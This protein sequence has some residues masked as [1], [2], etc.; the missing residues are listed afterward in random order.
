MVADQSPQVH[1]ILDENS[2]ATVWGPEDN[3]RGRLGLS[4]EEEIRIDGITI[5]FEGE[6]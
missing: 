5:Y 2:T 3:L 1:L 4:G 6:I